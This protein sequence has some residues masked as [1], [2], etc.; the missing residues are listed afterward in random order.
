MDDEKS[1][2][3]IISTSEFILNKFYDVIIEINNEWSEVKCYIDNVVRS[4]HNISDNIPKIPMQFGSYC[5]GPK[6]SVLRFTNLVIT[7]V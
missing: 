6:D 1:E 4:T 2:T 5:Y 7:E 3:E